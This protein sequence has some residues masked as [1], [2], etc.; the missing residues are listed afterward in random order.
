MKK[1]NFRL[2]LTFLTFLLILSSTAYSGTTI[3]N[4]TGTNS[5]IAGG[6]KDQTASAENSL[7]FGIKNKA[8]AENTATFGIGNKA[9]GKYS[10]AFGYMNTTKGEY[11]VTFGTNNKVQKEKSS[12]F[13]VINEVDGKNSTVIGTEY[14]VTGE[15]SGAFGVGEYNG[16]HQYKNEGNNSYMIGNKNKITMG[17]DDNF[18]LG[19]ENKIE[20]NGKNA[21]TDNFILGNKVSIG[22]G[23][24]NSVALGN[25]STVSASNVVSVGSKGNE[26]KITNVADGTISENSTDAING[27]QLYKAMQNSNNGSSNNKELKNEVNKEIK[28]IRS[29]VNTQIDDVKSEVKSVGSLSAALAGLHPMQ[30]D[31]KAP[32]QVMASVGHY[33]NKDSVAVGASYYFNDSFMM[34]TGIALSGDKKAKTM[35][36][37][38][39]TLKLGKGSRYT[40]NSQF[41]A[42]NE[43]NRIT[44]EN[45]NLKTEINLLNSKNKEQDEKIKKLEEKLDSLLKN[46]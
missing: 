41:V 29:E 43:V 46:K 26:R 23:I 39:F 44:V 10:S 12:A 8:T 40:E 5:V 4:G 19:N 33:K 24:K 28:N 34:S 38:G 2:K 16:S 45:Q 21:S 6:D 35:A 18:I 9:E 22:E 25:K 17:S 32:T 14:K 13:G 36:N 30:Y 7:A 27:R 3:N 15:S 1:N 31:P 37:V 11:S 42:S 20:G